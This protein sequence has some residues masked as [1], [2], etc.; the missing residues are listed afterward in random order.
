MRE[1]VQQAVSGLYQQTALVCGGVRVPGWMR[2]CGQWPMQE[3]ERGGMQAQVLLRRTHQQPGERPGGAQRRAVG[4]GI[5]DEHAHLLRPAHA[6]ECLASRQF[7]QR[8]RRDHHLDIVQLRAMLD[9]EMFSGGMPAG[10]ITCRQFHMVQPDPPPE[11]PGQLAVEVDKPVIARKC[12][13]RARRADLLRGGVTRQQ[14]RLQGED[15]GVCDGRLGH[16]NCPY[17]LIANDS[18]FFIKKSWA[19]VQ[20]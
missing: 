13:P 15:R 11:R 3:F 1:V 4:A 2:E 20:E 12:P 5:A 9:M 16:E 14:A 6:L 17:F 8:L 19:N 18:R 10:E 7:K